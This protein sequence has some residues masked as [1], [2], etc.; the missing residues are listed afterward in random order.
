MRTIFILVFCLLACAGQAICGEGDASAGVDDA[1]FGVLLSQLQDPFSVRV[2]APVV[3]TPAKVIATAVKSVV[4][5]A[6]PS[7]PPK[8]P[9]PALDLKVSG[10]LWGGQSPQAIIDDHV[11]G[12]GETVKNTKV[13]AIRK[14]E[15]EVSAKGKNFTFRVEK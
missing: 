10:V 2:P 12:I 4:S 13:I 6:K 1:A 11:V 14:S 15:V 5:T 7:A 9:E 8:P 3:N